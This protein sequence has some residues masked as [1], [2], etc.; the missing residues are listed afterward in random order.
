MKCQFNIVYCN[1]RQMKIRSFLFK[2]LKGKKLYSIFF[3]LLGKLILLDKI[4]FLQN[5]QRKRFVSSFG[6]N[7]NKKY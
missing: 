4:F 6:A 5:I 7:C 2:Y 1:L 3:Y